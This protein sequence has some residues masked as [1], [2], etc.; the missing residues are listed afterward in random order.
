MCCFIFRYYYCLVTAMAPKR[1]Y[2]RY[3]KIC[4]ICAKIVR[5]KNL[6][7][8]IREQH[9]NGYQGEFVPCLVAANHLHHAPQPPPNT[10]G[11]TVQTQV[12]VPPNNYTFGTLQNW[13]PQDL[14]AIVLD[15]LT[16][17]KTNCF[18]CGTNGEFDDFFYGIELPNHS[19]GC[20]APVHVL[21]PRYLPDILKTYGIY[22]VGE[23]VIV[24]YNIAKLLEV[25]CR[26]L[27][28]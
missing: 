14:N 23:V 10:N 15:I 2:N 13:T 4:Y 20:R 21:L 25:E 22:D 26:R 19:H 5:C 28:H 27:G 7:R 6:S 24:T 9:P 8:H 3:N 12:T 18:S 1:D 16:Q 11:V 17:A